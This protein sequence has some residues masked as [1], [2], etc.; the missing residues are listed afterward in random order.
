MTIDR[1]PSS[2]LLK[3]ELLQSPPC[4]RNLQAVLDTGHIRRQRI[5]FFEDL[6][7]KQNR[8]SL[9]IRRCLYQHYEGRRV[10]AMCLPRYVIIIKLARVQYLTGSDVS[11]IHI[12]L[13][14]QPHAKAAYLHPC[15]R[16]HFITNS[17]PIF[18]P[19]KKT[20][21]TRANQLFHNMTAANSLGCLTD[22][23]GCH[24]MCCRM[25][26]KMTEQHGSKEH[27]S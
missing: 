20:Q 25:G 11:D 12:S 3:P 21:L 9:I 27:T 8:R 17:Q 22:P 14:G 13:Q 5:H 19:R 15:G 18:I 10:L 26:H 23:P 2:T 1:L 24:S 4:F 6:R 7:S 16:E